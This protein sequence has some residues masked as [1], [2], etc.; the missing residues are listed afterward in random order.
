[1]PSKSLTTDR[2][3]PPPSKQAAQ[4]RWRAF[5]EASARR[6]KARDRARMVQRVDNLLAKGAWPTRALFLTRSGLWHGGLRDGLGS[7]PGRTVGL[8]TYVRAGADPR[9]QPKALF[10]QA[11]YLATYPEL[12][13]S[14]W[15]PL[16]HYLAEGDQA[17]F[18]PHPLFDGQGYRSRHAVK[19]AASR[20]TALQHFIYAGAR[21]GYDPHPL[22]DVQFYVSHCVEVA[23]TGENPLIHYLRKGWRDGIDPHPL[24]SGKRYRERNPEAAQTGAAPLLHFVALGALG[25]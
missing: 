2:P 19:I 1:V 23:R 11:W 22:F 15:P 16:V 4:A 20:L 18:N 9:L 12:A 5:Q 8:L 17:G 25:A 24:F 14:A 7:T 21:E 3:T 13:G 6:Y 10:D